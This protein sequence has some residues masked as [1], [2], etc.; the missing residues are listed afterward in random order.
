MNESVMNAAVVVLAGTLFGFGL[1]LSGMVRPEVVLSFLTLRDFGL[2]LVMAGGM[3]VAL[4]A[5]QWLPRTHAAPW[6][7]GSFEAHTARMHR[8]TFIGAA[9]FGI[10]WG[11]NGVCPGPAIAGLGTGNWQMLWVLLGLF[12]GAGL[13]GLLADQQA[14]EALPQEG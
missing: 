4:I 14:P 11:M 3:T 2:V 6:L 10:G 5:Y 12:A 8:E 9:I 13:Q 7:G 1:A